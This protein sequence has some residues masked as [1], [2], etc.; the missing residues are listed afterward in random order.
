[1]S[2]RS[3]GIVA[4]FILL[5]AVSVTI[6]A[7]TLST[8]FSDPVSP[9]FSITVNG[10]R[11]H[12]YYP[13]RLSVSHASATGAVEAYDY[14]RDG[15]PD[16][17]SLRFSIKTGTNSIGFT[18]AS[19]YVGVN[20]SGT[21]GTPGRA[22]T[23]GNY[24]QAR[25]GYGPTGNYLDAYFNSSTCINH[26]SFSISRFQYETLGTVSREFHVTNV[27]VTITD[28]C[29]F[30]GPKGRVTISYSDPAKLDPAGNPEVP[31]TPSGTPT[32]PTTPGTPTTPTDP[33]TGTPS[34]S[35]RLALTVP[36][37]IF[38]TPPS[39][40]NGA[41]T[42]ATVQVTAIRELEG[43]VEL[44]AWSEPEGLDISVDPG[45][46]PNPG[47]GEATLT[48]R[49]DED[50]VPR[51][52]VVNVVATADG[53]SYPASFIVQVPCEVPS[54]LGA[55]Q[56]QGAS[57]S[58]GGTA[59]LEAR[60]SGTGP[61]RYQWYSGQSGMTFNPIDRANGARYTTPALNQTGLY[62]VRVTNPC[63]SVDSQSATVSVP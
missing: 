42:T 53:T 25:N 28:G 49:V 24:T 51:D 62:W 37:S 63:G 12:G 21:R 47:T 59:S 31:I 60:P 16:N 19:Y 18:S 43:D 4:S 38:D 45:V 40:T 20:T 52:Y 11:D 30:P 1:M 26:G 58:R 14:D 17:M 46:L 15:R 34:T 2:H 32:T 8:D 36:Q 35:P 27:V 7:Q 48:I 5:A 50:A 9:R 54:F 3:H 29:S 6:E 55:N 41:S 56:P 57:I 61:F 13:R 44:S 22:L 10:D 39:V 23:T 33:E